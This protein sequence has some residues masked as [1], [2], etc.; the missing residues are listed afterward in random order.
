MKRGCNKGCRGV[1]II[2]IRNP[3]FPAATC[4]HDKM[5]GKWHHYKIFL[6]MKRK[7]LIPK[8]N[9]SSVNQNFQLGSM[10]FPGPWQSDVECK[11]LLTQLRFPIFS[12][13]VLF[14]AVFF[15]AVV[16]GYDGGAGWFTGSC[17]WSRRVCL[18]LQSHRL[19]C[20]GSRPS[21]QG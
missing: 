13:V 18:L 17:G 8:N 20:G 19:G 1:T 14:A 15:F 5:H 4:F 11:T 12:A 21:G 10:R 2:L 7:E 9:F 16:L 6:N 3:G